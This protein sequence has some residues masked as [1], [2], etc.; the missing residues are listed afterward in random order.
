MILKFI[1]GGSPCIYKTQVPTFFLVLEY[2]KIFLRYI[3]M[4]EADPLI[5]L[6]Q[7]FLVKLCWDPG[8]FTIHFNLFETQFPFSVFYTA[9]SLVVWIQAPREK[10]ESVTA[11]LSVGT[12]TRSSTALSQLPKIVTDVCSHGHMIRHCVWLSW[13]HITY[14]LFVKNNPNCTPARWLSGESKLPL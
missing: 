7:N 6:E 10:T 12:N 3:R 2:Y 13:T 1:S 4:T 8:H 11:I 14:N 9:R 5:V